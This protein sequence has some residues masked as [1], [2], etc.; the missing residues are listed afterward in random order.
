MPQN[1]LG[2]NPDVGS[3]AIYRIEVL[4][5]LP[6]RYTDCFGGMRIET[7]QTERGSTVSSLV[8][9]VDDQSA[10][11]GMLDSLAEYHLPILAVERIAEIGEDGEPQG[12][13]SN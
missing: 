11:T 3:P 10:L 1:N 13:R 12:P 8:G 4:G 2:K 6:E 9:P 7:R 5:D